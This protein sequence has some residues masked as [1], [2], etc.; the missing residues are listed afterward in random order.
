M[1]GGGDYTHF[2]RAAEEFA[3]HP[4]SPTAITAMME[5]ACESPSGAIRGWASQWLK[6][7]C[8]ILIVRDDE[9]ESSDATSAPA[10]GI[11]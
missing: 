8:N 4:N 5:L 1:P 3:A 6:Q 7:K 11:L 9:Q 2:E 10:T